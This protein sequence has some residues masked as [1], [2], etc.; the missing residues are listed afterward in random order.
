[1]YDSSH[2]HWGVV[3]VDLFL[4]CCQLSESSA[5]CLNHFDIGSNHGKMVSSGK[6]GVLKSHGC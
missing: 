3:E 6:F 2:G 1:M 5:T 4:N